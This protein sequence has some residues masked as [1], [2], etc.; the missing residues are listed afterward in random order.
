VRSLVATLALLTLAA[1]ACKASR[2]G[3][4]WAGIDS[5]EAG[6]AA[7]DILGKEEATR[8]SPLYGKELVVVD[9]KQGEDPNTNHPAWVISLETFDHVLSPKCL[10]LWGNHTPFITHV[11]YDLD[12][13]PGGGGT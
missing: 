13:C 8:T 2:E 1:P 4:P 6:N 10:F 12:D 9:T 7:S 3:G 11:D 5:Y